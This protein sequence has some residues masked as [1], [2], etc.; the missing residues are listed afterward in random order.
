MIRKSILPGNRLDYTGSLINDVLV[1]ERITNGKQTQYGCLCLDC[2]KVFTRHQIAIKN[3]SLR[4]DCKRILDNQQSAVNELY[5]RKKY[6]AKRRGLSFEL[7]IEHF[8]KLIESNCVYCDAMPTEVKIQKYY[9]YFFNSI[10]RVNS[11]K[12]YTYNNCVPACMNCNRAKWQ[13]D[14]DTFRNYIKVV[15]QHLWR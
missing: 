12:G 10:D 15:Y 1:C 11:F 9:N 4:C 6:D 13:M 8:R 2:D 14:I 5:N 3:K 7:T